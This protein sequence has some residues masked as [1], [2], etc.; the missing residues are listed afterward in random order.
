MVQPKIPNLVLRI[1]NLQKIEKIKNVTLY[2]VLFTLKKTKIARR[3]I[4][5]LVSFQ[6]EQN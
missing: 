6:S 1:H 2:F 3:L 4:K 5:M